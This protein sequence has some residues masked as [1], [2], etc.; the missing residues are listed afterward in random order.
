MVSSLLVSLVSAWPQALS[1]ASDWWGEGENEQLLLLPAASALA[2]SV[3]CW[4]G[5]LLLP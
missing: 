2:L 5:L 4:S 1:I 3:E